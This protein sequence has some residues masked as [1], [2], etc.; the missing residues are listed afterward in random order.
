MFALAADLRSANMDS[1]HMLAV[2]C[3]AKD[4]DTGEHVLRV[5]RY[6]ELLARELGFMAVEVQEFGYSSILHDVGKVHIP[7]AILQK[8]AKLTDEE[9]RQSSA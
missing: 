8:P 7:D 2:A 1:L 4:H 9:R 5:K 3:E 6:T